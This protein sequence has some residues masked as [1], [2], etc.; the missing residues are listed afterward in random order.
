[1]NCIRAQH[2][3]GDNYTADDIREFMRSVIRTHFMTDQTTPHG[4]KCLYA[5]GRKAWNDEGWGRDLSKLVQAGI[6][7]SLANLCCYEKTDLER[8]LLDRLNR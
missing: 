2:R 3:D 4:F 8:A 5:M 6:S 7:Q 1:M